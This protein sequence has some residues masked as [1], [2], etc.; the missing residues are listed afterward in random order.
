MRNKVVTIFGGSGFVGRHL[1]RRVARLGATIRVP[2]RRPE[3]ANFLR[4]LGDVGQIVLEPWDADAPGALERLIGESTYVVNLIGILA[5][6]RKGV[7]EAVQGRLPGLIGTAAREAG[8]RRFVQVSAI[9]ADRGSSS[10]Y[11]R[12]KAEG[13]EAARAA[14][15]ETVVLR[16]SVIFGP[17]DEF[18]N[19]FA[20]MA[21][22]SPALPLIGGGGTRFQPVY[23]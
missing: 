8:V 11:A 1:V 7:F 20:R 13:E 14:F 21:M 2:T 10:L 4:P 22:I 5:A 18:F 6:R 12:T 16:P 23:V 17:E 9:G 15:P 19:R 3:R